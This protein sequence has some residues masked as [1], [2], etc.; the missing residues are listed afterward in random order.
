MPSGGMASPFSSDG[1]GGPGAPGSQYGQ[2]FQQE[3]FQYM[4]PQGYQ[5]VQHHLQVRGC[6]RAAPENSLSPPRGS[7]NLHLPRPTCHVFPSCVSPVKESGPRVDQTTSPPSTLLPSHRI[8]QSSSIGPL[9]SH[10]LIWTLQAPQQMGLSMS[11][12]GMHH[13]MFS[14]NS[15]VDL[16]NNSMGNYNHGFGLSPGSLE[17]SQL[18]GGFMPTPAASGSLGGI[19]P[20]VMQHQHQQQQQY[21][22]LNPRHQQPGMG[23]APPAPMFAQAPMA[24][25]FQ[26]LDPEGKRNRSSGLTAMMVVPDG[27]AQRVKSGTLQQGPLMAAM[28]ARAA[29][30]AAAAAPAPPAE[31]TKEVKSH[32]ARSLLRMLRA[33]TGVKTPNNIPITE[34]ERIIM[35]LAGE[36]APAEVMQKKKRNAGREALSVLLTMYLQ[37]PVTMAEAA[38]CFHNPYN[39]CA[40]L[41]P[42]PLQPYSSLRSSISIFF[43]PPLLLLLSL[44]LLVLLLLV[45]LLLL[46]RL[47]LLFSLLFLLLLL[48]LLFPLLFLLLFLPLPPLLLLL[49]P[50]SLSLSLLWIPTPPPPP[51]IDHRGLEPTQFLF[52]LLGERTWPPCP[53]D[54]PARPPSAAKSRPASKRAAKP[55]APA[56]AF[57]SGVREQQQ[58]QQMP[59][60]A[61]S[62]ASVSPF[63]ASAGSSRMAPQKQQPQKQQ[64]QP[65]ISYAPPAAIESPFAVQ[66]QGPTSPF[67]Q[68]E[69][70]S[71]EGFGG[72]KDEPSAAAG[73][74][75]DPE[76]LNMSDEEA[77]KLRDASLS[78]LLAAQMG[79]GATGDGSSGASGHPGGAGAAA[80]SSEAAAGA[81]GDAAAGAS[82]R[83]GGDSAMLPSMSGLGILFGGTSGA[84]SGLRA[85][86]LS[87]LL[88]SDLG[89]GKASSSLSGLLPDLNDNPRAETL[90]GIL[91]FG[92][93]DSS[94]QEITK[95]ANRGHADAPHGPQDK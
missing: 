31:A 5:P 55:R 19:P 40:P 72:F 68:G 89:F 2:Q 53:E 76:T 52:D 95:A 4:A 90:S 12:G 69:E 87:G 3:R 83:E 38:A 13:G 10:P 67:E 74:T 43:P 11:Q 23:Q 37:K 60:S 59:P 20:E 73:K 56:P 41:C 62:S 47:L 49:F 42:A 57:D 18:L 75:E 35:Q 28:G 39:R 33:G 84:I 48:L 32:T 21:S 64:Q 80:A 34:A 45:L 44:F 70:A 7:C 78:G 51:S 93:K 81:S 94:W 54:K 65:P 88:G 6:S 36:F 8:A 61:A 22:Y 82:S 1:V 15:S 17:F 85:Q 16:G 46:R 86:S 92:D 14:N 66:M 71:G 79:I 58:Q 27:K 9:I 25:A 50:L 63:S 29:P 77:A 91:S 26:L 30:A 24:P